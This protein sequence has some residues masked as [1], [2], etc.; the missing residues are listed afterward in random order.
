MLAATA[1]QAGGAGDAAPRP[2]HRLNVHLVTAHHSYCSPMPLPPET[3]FPFQ[4][5]SAGG[6]TRRHAWRLLSQRP[7][8][9]CG[10][11]LEGG[12]RGTRRLG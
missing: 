5:D 1:K 12:D 6:T 8:N 10:P 9:R 2:G 4:K 11:R 7:S 3:P